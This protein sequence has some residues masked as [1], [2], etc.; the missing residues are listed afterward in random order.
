VLAKF[1]KLSLEISNERKDLS[2]NLW[3]FFDFGNIEKQI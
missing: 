2:K 1:Q 3:K